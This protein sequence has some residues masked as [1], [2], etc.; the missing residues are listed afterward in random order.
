MDHRFAVI[1]GDERMRYAALYLRRIGG[2]TET[3]A[4]PGLPDTC[5]GLKETLRRAK[6]VLLPM[7]ALDGGG[8]IR[9]SQGAAL[10]AE[11]V[12][13]YVRGDATV[14]GGRLGHAAELIG[15]RAKTEDY[16]E[17]ET[18][19]IAN[20]VLTA[21][22]AVLLAMEQSDASLHGSR[23]LVIGAGRIGMR[24]ARLLKALGADVTVT[25]RKDSDFARI[26]AERMDADVTG[27]YG[28]GLG[29]YGFV[30]NTVPAQVLG[31]EQ[32]E[33]L[34]PD[35]VLIELASAPGGFSPEVCRMLDRQYVAGGGLPGRV[36]PKTAGET[37]AAEIA[38]R[39]RRGA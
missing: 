2:E 20:A 6:A 7:P 23:C 16:A 11:D 12:A 28:L 15:R 29:R 19:Q 38:E 39:L 22:G 37:I 8:H 36:A 30:F 3:Y 26:R 31:A 5:A 10:T 17:W 32:I 1:G 14:F 13:Q 24:L 35:C 34:R 18:L 9:N 21:E 4:V 33:R 27:V 25:A